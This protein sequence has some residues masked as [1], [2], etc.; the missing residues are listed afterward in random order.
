MRAFEHLALRLARLQTMLKKRSVI[1]KDASDFEFAAH[2]LNEDD[3]FA[4][5]ID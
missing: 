2:R 5:I 1:P 4:R 3:Y